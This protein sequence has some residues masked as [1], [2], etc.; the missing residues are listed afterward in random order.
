MVEPAFEESI[1]FVARAMK[2]FGLSDLGLV[3]P[4]ATL[5]KNGRMRGGHAQDIL[6]EMKI[7]STFEE[8]LEGADLV[9]G[10]TDQKAL[11]GLNLLRQ[12]MT[13]KQL[14]SV[15]AETTGT[16]ALVFGREGTGLNNREL[17]HCNAVVTIP[18][19]TEY[20]ALNLSHAAAIVFY[21]SFSTSSNGTSEE[22][23]P[24]EVKTAILRYMLE[25]TTL[26]GLEDYKTRLTLKALGN[27]LGRSAVRKREAS[28]LAGALRQ[29]AE[30]I[31][32]Q[33]PSRRV[34]KIAVTL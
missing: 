33:Q 3:N 24:K 5:S 4:T 30:T 17:D 32:I 25:S 13:P 16:V 20:S 15:L 18:T 2:N 6:S 26:A 12:C 1:G 23:A 34:E 11:S 27:V 29:I 19:A 21:E 31:Q 9:V 28:L 7:Y 22:L 10:T 8:S 14:A